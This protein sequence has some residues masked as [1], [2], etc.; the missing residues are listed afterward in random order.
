[1]RT[2]LF[3]GV[4]AGGT[5]FVVAVGTGPGDLRRSEEIPTT[6]PEDTMPLVVAALREM[7]G[8]KVPD[9]IGLAAFGPV[10]VRPHS[11]N[12]GQILPSCPKL[13][14]AGFNLVAAIQEEFPGV[15]VACDTDVN[16]AA[17]AEHTW[18]AGQGADP[19]VYL[20]VGTGIGGGLLCNGG[21]VHGL[22]HPEMGHI[23][24]PQ[25]AEDKFRG[26]CPSHGNCLEGL[27][28]GPAILARCGHSLSE[29]SPDHEAFRFQAHYLG[30]ALATFTCV[31]SPVRIILGGGVMHTPGLIQAVRLAMR[32]SLHNYLALQPILEVEDSGYV[33]LP[34]LGDNAGVLGAIA[35]AAT[36]AR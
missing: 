15:V 9:G 29:L 10:D 5:K 11:R 14:W 23:L 36:A 26:V 31:L 28:S 22:L 8:D 21:L 35:L 20:T 4:E 27:A 1:M 24:M 2:P 6:S 7:L 34:G 33:V 30:L 13:A 32:D 16:A 12:F 19:L 18:G 25:P 17:L 3:A